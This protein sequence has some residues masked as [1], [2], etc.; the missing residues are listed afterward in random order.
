MPTATLPAEPSAAL[1]AIIARTALKYDLLPYTSN[2]F[3]QTQ[4]G[5]L[6]A[7]ARVFGLDVTP[8][9][10][11][12]VLELGCA[13]GGNII[14]LAARH[15]DARF[16]GVDLS[17]TQVAAGRARI[18]SLGLANIQILCQSFT[19]LG[20]ADGT[21]DYIICHGVYSWVPGPVRDA[22][23]SICRDRLSPTGI[24]IVSYN[25]LPGWRMLQALRDAFLIHVPD[26]LDSRLRVQAARDFLTFLKAN[27]SDGSGY[28][29]IVSAWSDRFATLPDDYIAH[30]FLEEVNEPCT[31]RDFIERA[32]VHGL[33]FLA[34]AEFASMILDN[35]P[36]HV[37]AGIRDLGRN[38][39]LATEQYSDILTGR[40]FRQSHLVAEGRA[41]V[42]SR[43]LTP[44]R[45]EGLHILGGPDLVVERLPDQPGHLR[46]GHGRSLTTTAPCVLDALEALIARYP[47]S[48]TVDDVMAALPEEART[49]EN[50]DHV[51]DALFRMV[52]AGIVTLS[53]EP[54][55]AAFVVADKPVACPLVRHDAGRGEMA[56]TNLRHERV[57]LD[58]L[59]QALL[60]L[61]DGTRDAAALDRS[62]MDAVKA[63]SLTFH[64]D[65]VAIRAA[66]ELE[67]VI[68]QQVQASLQSFRQ[69]AL[70]A[71]PGVSGR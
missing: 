66:G 59:G 32:Q 3:P 62:V 33:A 71:G 52:M 64:R 63:G 67:P 61:L 57:A 46:D 30:E 70:L 49:A 11:A 4:P 36:A 8:L 31:F 34:E 43:N 40:T 44:E 12:R 20:E 56:T 50:R 38:Q 16:L 37:A 15:P 19:E 51:R 18:A 54:V 26:Q 21:F 27:G 17:R 29:Q 13:G 22:I 60:P 2:P 6:G 1:D 14:P 48:S 47:S 10:S 7:L 28:G 65:G 55:A 23:L 68:A 39:L 58:S 9:A 53:C 42:I 25:V 45:I 24:A 69:N 41:S 35:R 5:R